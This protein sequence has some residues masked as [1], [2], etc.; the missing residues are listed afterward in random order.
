MQVTST[1]LIEGAKRL[2]DHVSQARRTMRIACKFRQLT[3]DG[4]TLRLTPGI[5]E[6]VQETFQ[7]LSSRSPTHDPLVVAAERFETQQ[8]MCLATL[9]N[10]TVRMS[11]ATG[12]AKTIGNNG[13]NAPLRFSRN[14]SHNL[15]PPFLRLVTGSQDRPQEMKRIPMH[16][17]QSEQVHRVSFDPSAEPDRIHNEHESA[18]GDCMRP[19]AFAKAR[20]RPCMTFGK[21]LR[22]HRGATRLLHNSESFNERSP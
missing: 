5:H 17:A 20:E 3:G 7:L 12:A 9:K 16:C 1:V 22:T 6:R 4:R 10:P 14:L 11:K 15:M 18:R 8:E 21:R 13:Y 19:A 2:G